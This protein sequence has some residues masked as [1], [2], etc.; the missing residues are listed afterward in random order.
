MPR[1]SVAD[2]VALYYE[3]RGEGQPLLLLNGLSQST[4]NWI[5]QSRQLAKRFQVIVFDS[6]GQGKTP[7][8]AAP[9]SAAVLLKDIVAL[10]EHLGLERVNVCGFSYGARIALMFAAHHP[11]RV[12]RLILTSAGLKPRFARRMIFR[13]WREV[14][15]TGGLE[16]MAWCAL[17]YILGADFIEQYERMIP[18][19]IKA[20]KQRNSVEGLTALMDIMPDFPDAAHDAARVQAPSLVLASP[21]DPLVDADSARALAEA[22]AR[23]RFQLVEGCGHTIPIE[24][25]EVWR[26]AVTDFLEEPDP[27]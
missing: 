23:G 27:S 12:A 7:V 24:Q 18:S 9:L 11:S 17:P 4:A 20:S 21:H 14:L 16:A 2:D 19:M 8:G 13:S 3:V 26:A 22:I 5:S 15:R 6:R 10:L 25:P 1:L